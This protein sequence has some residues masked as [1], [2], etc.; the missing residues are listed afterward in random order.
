MTSSSREDVV[1]W[2]TPIEVV[3]R[4]VVEVGEVERKVVVAW[5]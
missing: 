3:E 4:M 2:T 5:T 1:G